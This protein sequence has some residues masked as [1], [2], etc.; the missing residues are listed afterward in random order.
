M[1]KPAF[2]VSTRLTRVSRPSR[3]GF[4]IRTSG[5][6]GRGAGGWSPP[7]ARVYMNTQVTFMESRRIAD[8]ASIARRAW[9][10]WGLLT[11]LSVAA[12]LLLLPL[13][14]GVGIESPAWSVVPVLW[15][16]FAVPATIATYGQCFRDAFADDPENSGITLNSEAYLRGVT[17]VWGVLTVGIGL[18]LGACVLAGSASPA[19]WPG[20]LMLMLLVLARPSTNAPGG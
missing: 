8:S 13:A 12:M 9:W 14:E 20:A 3:L 7:N 1:F 11:G 6:P 18:S 2:A 17:S 5:S 19:V 16:I 4:R 10:R 15:L